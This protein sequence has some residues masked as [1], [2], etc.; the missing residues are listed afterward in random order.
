MVSRKGNFNWQTTMA[1]TMAKKRADGGGRDHAQPALQRLET[2]LREIS[3]HEQRSNVEDVKR[4][5]AETQQ[6]LLR[7]QLAQAQEQLVAAQASKMKLCAQIGT[8][9]QVD[10]NQGGVGETKE[11]NDRELVALRGEL[12]SLRGSHEIMGKKVE[13]LVEANRSQK[14]AYIRLVVIYSFAISEPKLR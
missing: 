2:L 8:L 5:S 10:S 6:R 9:E 12:A 13:N 1:N 7:E 11:Q 14:N 3:C 4:A